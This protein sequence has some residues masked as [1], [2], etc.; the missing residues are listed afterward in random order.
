MVLLPPTTL[1]ALNQTASGNSTS[2]A[3]DS[4]SSNSIDLIAL[5]SNSG[6]GNGDN[7]TALSN[8]GVSDTLIVLHVGIW[9][10]LTVS[11]NNNTIS[12]NNILSGLQLLSCNSI[13][14][15]NNS[16]DGN[17]IYILPIIG[18]LTL[19]MIPVINANQSHSRVESKVLGV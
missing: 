16:V 19:V 17:K 2:S 6:N 4:S 5:L 13:S 9:Q 11:Q 7:N 10:I 15:S 8:D 18:E 14:V 1:D 3:A 12:G